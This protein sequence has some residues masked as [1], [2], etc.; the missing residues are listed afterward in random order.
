MAYVHKICK[1]VI[2]STWWYHF[3]FN[4][5][6][7][8]CRPIPDKLVLIGNDVLSDVYIALSEFILR[9]KNTCCTSPTV[10]RFSWAI[11]LW[12]NHNSILKIDQLT[13]ALSTL[14]KWLMICFYCAG[15]MKF[16][17]MENKKLLSDFVAADT[18]YFEWAPS[19]DVF[20]TGTLSK[21][22]HSWWI[23]LY[24]EPSATHNYWT[25]LKP[26]GNP[27]AP[28]IPSEPLPTLMSPSEPLPTPSEVWTSS[29]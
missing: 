23:L 25:A 13:C 1:H 2:S 4:F 15:K 19:G 18:T 6:C 12:Q 11:K 10:G 5:Q 8:L 20:I 29:L 7:R 27:S 3:D 21:C 17:E 16:Y 22:L 24:W 14:S 28:L 9:N 26:I